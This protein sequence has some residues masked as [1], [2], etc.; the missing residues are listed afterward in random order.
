M[1]RGLVRRRVRRAS[2]AADLSVRQNG[3]LLHSYVNLGRL[4]A[5][6]RREPQP[7]QT[8]PGGPC[9]EYFPKA[10]LP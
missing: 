6:S 7:P 4:A 5:P 9:I 8:E 1:V 2:P 3:A 10:V